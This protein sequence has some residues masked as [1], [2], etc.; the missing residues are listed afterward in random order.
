MG[1]CPGGELSYWVII[2]VGNRL[3][4]GSRP[5]GELSG[6]ELSSGEFS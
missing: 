3:G 2:L 4:W 1:N 5:S 6:W